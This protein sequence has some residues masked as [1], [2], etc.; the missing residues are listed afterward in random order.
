MT[1]ELGDWLAELSESEPLRAAEVGAALVAVMESASLSGLVIA[2]QAGRSAGPV[3]DDPRETVDYAYQ[4]QLDQ[5][6]HVRRQLADMASARQAAA[7][8]LREQQ[9]AGA[10]AAV[11][12]AL[13]ERK[14]AAQL[15]EDAFAQLLTRLRIKVDTFRTAKETAKARYTAAEA[16]LRIAEA[17]EAIGGDPDPD[18]D[19][20]RADYRAAEERLRALR[21]LATETIAVMRHPSWR[22]DAG[23]PSPA[24]APEPPPPP[25]AARAEP[26][27]GLLELRAD[28]LG[29]DIR[30]LL[31]E[32]PPGAVT[33]LAVLEG[34]AAV[35]EH[36]ADAIRLAG[37]LLTEI[38]DE[39]W[40]TDVG[41]IVLADRAELLARFFPADDGSI[42]RRS[43]VLAAMTSLNNLRA[44]LNLTLDEVAG[45]SGLSRHRVEAIEREG[46]RTARV[47]EAVALARALGARLELPTGSGP[48]AG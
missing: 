39:G 11:I 1:A 8:A 25:P 6:Q 36:G 40:P 22:A 14:A 12:A 18:L 33:L 32:E 24:D 9:A 45:R 43:G 35:S 30:V 34:P 48:V 47:H 23:H 15:Q 3:K 20:R 37:D 2:G 28:S 29:S 10:D 17:I 41:E 38:R 42:G 27:P 5:L 46:L 16:T 4:Q 31:A 21:Y 19:Q 13:A 26:V 44:D 7:V